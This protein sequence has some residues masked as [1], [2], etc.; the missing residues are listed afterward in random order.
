[1]FEIAGLSRN[2][3]VLDINTTPALY[4][5]AHLNVLYICV[6]V[7]GTVVCVL[8]VVLPL[9]RATISNAEAS[10]GNLPERRTR[11]TS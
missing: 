11:Q 8:L 10:K 7:L 1:M 6:V 2:N 9:A 4:P 3:C 5:H